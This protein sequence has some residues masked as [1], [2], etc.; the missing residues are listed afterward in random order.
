MKLV[1]LC[2]G[3]AAAITACEKCLALSEHNFDYLY[4]IEQNVCVGDVECE[5]SLR[6]VTLRFFAKYGGI[7]PCAESP[8][9]DC[10]S[11]SAKA[12]SDLIGDHCR[13]KAEL[14]D[15]IPSDSGFDKILSLRGSV[16]RLSSELS[17]A[18]KQLQD[19][20]TKEKT[21]YQNALDRLAA[22]Q[23]PI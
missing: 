6:D 20:I 13:R 8:V 23:T 7:N 9:Q 4:L 5:R 11:I 19:E 18:E 15:P 14:L 12:C 1:W 17:E 21:K 22:L 2:C 3:I 16:K 10:P